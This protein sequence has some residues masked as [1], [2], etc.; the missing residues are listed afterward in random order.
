MERVITII[1]E[2]YESMGRAF[3]QSGPKL[4]AAAIV[5]VAG[6]V[7]ARVAKAA[8]SH[9]LRAIKLERFAEK[10][11]LSAA[12]KRAEVDKTA[13]EIG[14]ALVYWTGLVF[15]MLA[16][17]ETLSIAGTRAM[18]AL[19][20]TIPSVVLAV[21]TLVVG[22]NLAS[23]V[24]KLAQTAAV[25]A[26]IRQAR[27]VRNATQLGLGV[28]VVLLALRQ[29]DIPAQLLGTTFLIIVGAASLALALAFGL[30]C[31]DLAAG[32]AR[33]TWQ[34]EQERSRALSEASELGDQVFP[35]ANERRSR[36]GRHLAA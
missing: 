5:V 13:T 4:V 12:L 1:K 36:S 7:L 8:M 25:N 30:G 29:F 18:T 2:T 23:F 27:L 16:T 15:T 35:N 26:E 24:A 21:V 32:I 10:V 20:D 9:V 11:G 3:A 22:L 14:C 28:L 33:S 31:R 34:S 17:L 6:L 19:V